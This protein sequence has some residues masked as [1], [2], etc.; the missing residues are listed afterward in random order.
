[1]HQTFEMRDIC[2][3]QIPP[4]NIKDTLH[5]MAPLEL[6]LLQHIQKTETTE[7]GDMSII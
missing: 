2:F 7:A 4:R 6:A 5:P 3:L 1:M